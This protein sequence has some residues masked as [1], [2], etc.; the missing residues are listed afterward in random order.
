MENKEYTLQ[1][2]TFTL[3]KRS[4]KTR[5]DTIDLFRDVQKHINDYT[6]DSK[7]ELDNA[8]ETDKEIFQS[9]YDA[10]LQIALY[11]FFTDGTNLK[12]L[13]DKCLNGEIDKIDY[14][15]DTDEEID[16]LILFGVNVF[17]DFFISLKREQT[18]Q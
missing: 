16:D 18:K 14:E 3:K 17:N 1:G 2:L 6:F 13:F 4:L 11:T 8:I 5:K 12:T 10:D 9:N 7:K 15:V